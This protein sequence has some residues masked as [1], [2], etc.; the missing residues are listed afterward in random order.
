MALG[1]CFWAVTV[2]EEVRGAHDT[3]RTWGGGARRAA[4][5]P[6]VSAFGPRTLTEQRISGERMFVEGERAA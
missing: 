5:R 6:C 1:R 3:W 4:A 2:L